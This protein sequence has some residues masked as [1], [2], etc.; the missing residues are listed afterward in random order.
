MIGALTFM[1][2][3]LIFF[4]LA[5]PRKCRIFRGHLCSNTVTVVLFFSDVE[6]YVPVKLCKTAGSIHLFK[7]IGH[8][9]PAQITL[10][11]RLL[12]DIVQIDWKEVLMTLNGNM[13][14]L[15]TSVIIPM[16]DKFGLRCI[17]RKRSLLLH[18]M[19]KQGISWYA[20]DSKEYLLPPPCLDNSEI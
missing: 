16:R 4:I 5:R 10:K 17:I 6:H 1:I 15:P 13:V 9:T 3:G 8:L 2:I 14:Y 20:L 11:R 19:L 7:I 12:W 18:V